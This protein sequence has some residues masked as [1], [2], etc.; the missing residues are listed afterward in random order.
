[1]LQFPPIP[2]WDAMHPLLIH[3]PIVLLLVAPLLVVVA[4]CLPPPKN[5]PYLTVA[6]ITILLGTL[7]LFLAASSGEE[8]AELADRAGGV[9]AVLAAH[10]SLA[11]TSEIVFSVLSILFIG[12]Y[13]WPIIWRGRQTRI[14]STTA[15]LV[16]LAAYS[17]GL[18]FLVNTAHAGGRLVH[19]FGVHAMVPQDNGHPGTQPV[20]ASSEAHEGD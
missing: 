4:A 12:L 14:S 17:I 15:P 1:M 6:L 16:F 10:E 11:S 19:E 18:L 9:N 13:L 20:A 3:F 5:R 2:T 8:A 7:G